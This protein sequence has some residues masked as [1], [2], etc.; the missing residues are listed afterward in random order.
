[1]N[2]KEIK[3][4][5][6][7]LLQEVTCDYVRSIIRDDPFTTIKLEDNIILLPSAADGYVPVYIFLDVEPNFTSIFIYI[8]KRNFKNREAQSLLSKIPLN[9]IINYDIPGVTST[10]LWESE[11]YFNKRVLKKIFGPKIFHKH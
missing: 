6:Q 2:I 5:D 8:E 11:G 9:N 4:E 7:V 1:M 10:M 3:Y